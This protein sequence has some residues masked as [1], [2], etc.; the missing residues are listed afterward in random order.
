M[1]LTDD[2]RA[3]LY[4]AKDRIFIKGLICGKTGKTDRQAVIEHLA[5]LGLLYYV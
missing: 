2:M 4:E 3:L 5:N 1:D